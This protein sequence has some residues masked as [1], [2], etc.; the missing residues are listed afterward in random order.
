MFH[1]I[2]IVAF[3]LAL[4][5]TVWVF[6]RT[7]PCGYTYIVDGWYFEGAYGG[8]GFGYRNDIPVGMPRMVLMKSRHEQSAR[9]WHIP[10]VGRLPGGFSVV[11][12]YWLLIVAFAAYPSLVLVRGPLRR[13]L[14]RKR[15]LCLNC[16]YDL[17]G[18]Q[19]L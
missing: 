7:R 13:H 17:R 6:A 15:G 5:A 11:L 19:E 3:T 2:V 16:G 1:R 18:S 8:I 9:T 4:L 10:K 14:R 12:P